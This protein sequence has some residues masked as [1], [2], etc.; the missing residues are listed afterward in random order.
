MLEARKSASDGYKLWQQWNKSKHGP[1]FDLMQRTRAHYKYAVRFCRKHEQQTEAD[2][3]AS[4]LAQKNCN[5]F[6]LENSL[7]LQNT[8]F[9]LYVSKVG[10]A[11]GPTDVCSLWLDHYKTLFNSVPYDC[12]QMEKLV[13]SVA[14]ANNEAIE[15]VSSRDISATLDAMLNNKAGGLLRL[16]H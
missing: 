16:A 7:S 10:S 8:C 5:C 1:L 4:C 13:S 2:K 12:T 6:F 15:H 3:Y 9:C 14:P 11:E